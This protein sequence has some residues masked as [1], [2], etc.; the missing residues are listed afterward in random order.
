[1]SKILFVWVFFRPKKLLAYGAFAPS[2]RDVTQIAADKEY[3]RRGIG[4]LLFQKMNESNK[5]DSVKI[6]NTDIG[7]SS[8]TAFLRSKNIGPE[9]KQFEM[10]KKL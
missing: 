8:M 3:H 9:G 7:C 4:S 5:H 6:I 10:I 1:M 2:S